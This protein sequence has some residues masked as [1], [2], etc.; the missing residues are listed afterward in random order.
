MA[1]TYNEAVEQTIVAGEQLHQIVNGL[2]TTDIIVEDGSAIPSVRKAL[3]DNFYFKDPVNWVAGQTEVVFNQ[4]RKFTD[5][6]WWY[7]PSATAT[8]PVSMGIT[9]IGDPL[10]HVY[11]LDA[12]VKLTPQIRE[13][14]RRSYADAGYDL[15]GDFS[16]VGLVV[17][18]ATDA[19]LWEPTG[20]AYAYSGTLPHT[21]GDEETPIGNPLWES[22]SDALN[23]VTKAVS[24][25]G[26]K[27]GFSNDSTDAL[28]AFINAINSGLYDGTE[29][30]IDGLYR[31]TEPLPTITRPFS[32]SGVI[33]ANS[34]IL[35]DNVTD[36][37]SIDLSAMT[38]N[39]VHSVVSHFAILTNKTIAGTG[40]RYLGNNGSSSSVKLE[41]D[42][43]RVDSLNRFLGN[44]SNEEW[45]IGIHIGNQ[46]FAAKPSEVR[47]HNAIVYG[48]DLNG[49]YST[50][51][52]SGSAGIVVEKSTNC[53]ITESK[54]FLLSDCGI[55]FRGQIEGTG[56]YE[57]QVVAVKRGIVYTETI[58][59]SNNH[60]IDHVHI[61]PYIT[62]IA[63][64]APITDPANNTPIQCFV[65]DVFIL[66]RNENIAKSSAFIGV[67]A[68]VRFSK[69]V[70]VTV[71][72][73]AKSPGI[74][75][76][77]GFRVGCGGNIL[78]NCHSH[79]MSYG[80]ETFEM[81]P[82]FAYDVALDEFFEEDSILGFASPAS[83]KLPAGTARAMS[84]PGRTY[85]RPVTWANQV[86]IVHENG[87]TIFDMNAG[88]I[89]NK[90]SSG[91][92]TSYRH[93]IN[94]SDVSMASLIGLGGD[95][96]T[97]N[98]G[99][100]VLR[101]MLTQ[102]SG[103]LTPEI[104]NTNTIGTS[105][106]PWAG[107]F[108][109]T[110]FTITSDERCKTIPLEITDAMLAAAAEVDWVQYQYL[111][112]VEA[113][114]QDGARWH[115]GVV[116]QRFVEAFSRHGLDAH[117]FGFL[118]Y[119][120]WEAT[121]EVIKV[122]PAV[123]DEEGNVLE[124]EGVEIIQAAIDAGSRYGIRYEEALALEAALQRRNY[125]R[126]LSRI[127]ALEAK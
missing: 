61:S 121:P 52:A 28:I 26:G 126:L 65:S 31:T 21:I 58:N 113:K 100:W 102:F 118:C 103:S 96:I 39:T 127:E 78:T 120:E 63:F 68:A 66:E 54:I 15:I 48:S 27:P 8:N 9:P 91:D 46:A 30:V 19:V 57:S 18:S 38:S 108:T 69:F 98:S 101:S 124:P 14:L 84:I 2:G 90:P 13:A 111:D 67:D 92:T 70:N 44:S 29:F 94:T 7:A 125:Q 76:K 71:W 80:I 25:F 117:N 47:I 119:D 50:L 34:A 107:G 73:N 45:L 114:G 49:S 109:Q 1:L 40:F 24:H 6:S 4:L 79:R 74:H 81:I 16:D 3:I 64:Q 41:F 10:W 86:S 5:G 116:A 99:N 33:P 83:F 87:T 60:Y 75:T 112:R 22:K 72:A 36:G 89:S 88:S 77:I 37:L 110:A 105:A 42:S 12:V 56:V 95:G 97:Q 32:L 123:L 85:R 115:F 104:A 122:V 11:S 51:T 82:G 17:N 23:K 20:I 55:L 53:I 35:F 62:G 93:L 106:R 59:P 43:M